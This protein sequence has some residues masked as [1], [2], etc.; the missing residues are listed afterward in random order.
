MENLLI[1]GAGKLGAQVYYHLSCYYFNKAKIL[2]FVDDVRS[3]N[4]KI[5]DGLVT[6]G[7]FK[8]IVNE[9][10]Y[11]PAKC[12]IV[13]AIGYGNMRGRQAV[14]QCI[15]DHGYKLFSV[16]H[17]KAIVEKNAT[18]G[19]GCIILSGAVIDQGVFIGPICYVDIGVTIGEDCH[20]GVNNYFS[21]SCVVGGNVKI[22]E[23]NFFG[24]NSTIVNDVTLGSNLI[25]NAQTLVHKNFTDNLQVIE[26]HKVIASAPLKKT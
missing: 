22:G 23:G 3:K 15:I 7:T 12:K 16:V 24:L 5:I 17:P 8:E 18:L 19:D 11:L 21:A 2:G 14:Y 25:V 26:I 10:K 6:L 4:E 1:Y 20:I 9:K 13:F